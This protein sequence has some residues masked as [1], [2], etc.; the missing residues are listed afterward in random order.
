MALSIIWIFLLGFGSPI[1]IT[2]GF[3]FGSWLGSLITITSL[4][5]GASIL[6]IFANYF[7]KDLIYE[8]FR[9]KFK[10][11]ETKFKNNEFTFMLIFRFIGGI[12]F[13]I[14]NILPILFN[15]K[16]KNYFFGTFLGIIPQTYIICSLGNGIEKIIENNDTLPSVKNLI[17]SPEIYIPIIG[18][19]FFI[20]ITLIFKKFFYKN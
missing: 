18:F 1:A 16:L 5:I 12:P 9:N 17:F 4:S 2:A 14:A 19:I 20:I 8:K 3:M 13:Q 11:L 7:F 6:Y 15:V 10:N